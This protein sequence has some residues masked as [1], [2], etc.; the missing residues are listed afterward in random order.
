MGWFGMALVDVLQS[1]PEDHPKRDTLVNILNRF[2]TAVV[3][4]QDKKTGLWYDIMDLP[5]KDRNYTEA[6]ASCMFVYTLAKGVRLGI[7]PSRYLPA[8]QK[9]YAGITSKFIKTE[10][11]QVNLHGTVSVSGLGGNPYRDG[12]FDYYMK[13]KVV[14]NDPKGVGAFLLASN[15]VEMIPTQKVGKNKL[16]MLD[17]YFNHET[18]KD[19]TGKTV[20]FHYVWDEM[21]NNGYS[22]LGEIFRQNGAKLG[23]LRDAPTY[24]NLSA[25]SVYIIVDPDTEKESPS[26]NYMKPEHVKAIYNWVKEGGV[27]A[28]FLNDSANAEFDHFNSLPEKFGIHFNK[29]GKNMVQGTNFQQGAVPIPANHSIFKNTRKAYIKEL[30]TLKVSPPATSVLKKDGDDI[31]AVAKVG[32]GFVFAVGDPWIYNEYTDG[33]KLPEEYQNFQAAQD[34]VKWLLTV[35]TNKNDVVRWKK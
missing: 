22:L 27:L 13:E 23:T 21:D 30:S 29:D 12:S 6:S 14:V 9:G 20:P 31:I 2:A 17:N 35:K 11:G 25:S 24:E 8:A 34:L 32:H 7:L 15:E 33:R 5:T 10:N 28:L 26:P 18:R 1:F 16:V 4:Y 19:I 3:K